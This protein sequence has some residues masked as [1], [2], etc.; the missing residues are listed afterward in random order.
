MTN[1]SEA[2]SPAPAEGMTIAEKILA[3]AAGRSRVGP[4]EYVDCRVDGV[5]AYETF[6]DTYDHLVDAGLPE[7]IPKVWNPARLYLMVEHVQPAG[8]LRQAER[9]ARL[10]QLVPRYRIKHFYDVTCGICHQ[11]MV[12][13]AHA[14]PG[15]LLVGSDSHSC[16]WGAL[17]CAS[18]GIGEMDLAYVV[19]FGELWFMVPESIRLEL[20][21]QP[22][23]WPVA[24]DVMLWLAGRHGADFALYK[25]IEVTGPGARA[26]SMDGRFTIAD[27]GIEVGAKFV[28]FECDERTREFLEGRTTQPFHPLQ[29]DPG[30]P[31][32]QTLHVD[33]GSLPPQV[34]APHSFDNVRPV[35][36]LTGV[37][38]DQACIGSCA[39]GR[40][41]DIEVAARILRGRRVHP[42]VRLLVSPASWEVY[43]RC[44]EAGLPQVVV[45]A[46]GQFLDPGC[47]ICIPA[48]AY[49]APGEVCLSATTR[50]YQ[51]RMGSPEAS[52][53]LANPATVA[54]SAVAGTVADPREVLT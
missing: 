39:N 54:W 11:M 23:P 37:R 10:R 31:Y 15:Q 36:E 19:T 42:G 12:D 27:H 45:D 51:G 9:A 47:G 20:T 40:F 41:E 26:L 17:N 6:V 25:S 5:M 43:K 3:R 28:I 2:E 30:A 21:G 35:D 14:L 16:M 1:R 48:R 8:S 52:I 4:G 38:I 13:H 50:N 18:T 29:A 46:G 7:G 53:Y 32:Q 33:L 49:L 22:P 34:A 24:K 44:V